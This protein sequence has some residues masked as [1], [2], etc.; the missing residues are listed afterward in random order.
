MFLCFSYLVLAH[1]SGK[2][3]NIDLGKQLFADMTQY[4]NKPLK[5][6]KTVQIPPPR[7]TQFGE[8][9]IGTLTTSL[10]TQFW[11]IYN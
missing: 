10:Q 5:N 2:L 4:I 1:C 7:A 6:K 9:L 8:K 3:K 11:L